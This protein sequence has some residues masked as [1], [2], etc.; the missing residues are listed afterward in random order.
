MRPDAPLRQDIA[1]E[2][3]SSYVPVREA[4]RQLQAQHLVVACARCPA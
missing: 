4:F 2:F 3:N 1:R